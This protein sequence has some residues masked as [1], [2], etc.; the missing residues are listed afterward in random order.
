MR[1]QCEEIS[2]F[3]D[4]YENSFSPKPLPPRC[5][6]AEG[7]CVYTGGALLGQSPDAVL[8]RPGGSYYMQIVLA[9]ECSITV[10]NDRGRNVFRILAFHY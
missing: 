2:R 3:F 6:H 4:I 5:A 1:E 9:D 8:S 10:I 7:T